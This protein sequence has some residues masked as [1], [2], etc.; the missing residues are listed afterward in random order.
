[1]N[2][3]KLEEQNG[4]NPDNDHSGT[5]SGSGSEDGDGFRHAQC[6]CRG[7]RQVHRWCYFLRVT[8]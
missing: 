3:F 8:E 2:S 6:N 5:T 4:E 1:M 7:R